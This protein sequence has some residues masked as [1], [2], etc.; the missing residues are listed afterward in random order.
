MKPIA[1]DR[2]L[3]FELVEAFIGHGDPR[4]EVAE[5]SRP[6]SVRPQRQFFFLL[7]LFIAGRALRV[8][9]ALTEQQGKIGKNK[10]N[11][12]NEVCKNRSELK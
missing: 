3:N 6:F 9:P 8:A 7:L 4:T 12:G 2:A 1:I 11:D 10:R 5:A